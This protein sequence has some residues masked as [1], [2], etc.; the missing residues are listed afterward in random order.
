VDEPGRQHLAQSPVHLPRRFAAPSNAVGWLGRS[1]DG[2]RTWLPQESKEIGAWNSLLSST[3]HSSFV[4]G[5]EGISRNS[6][7]ADSE[8]LASF[9]L[10]ARLD[11]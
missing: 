2:G 1:A 5:A 4:A 6:V 7:F 3:P 8:V 10:A 9:G 11:C